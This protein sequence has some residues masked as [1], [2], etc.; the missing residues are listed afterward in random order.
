MNT[1]QLVPCITAI[2]GIISCNI[3]IRGALVYYKRFVYCRNKALKKDYG[4][5]IC[6]LPAEFLLCT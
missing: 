1:I 3:S 4:I 2:I 5:I 6:L